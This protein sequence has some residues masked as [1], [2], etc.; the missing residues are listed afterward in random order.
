MNLTNLLFGKL[1]C[2]FADSDAGG[3]ASNDQPI[4][5]KS[6][7][8]D[9]GGGD[10]TPTDFVEFEGV[11]IPADAFDKVARERHKDAFESHE[12]REKWQ[13]ENTQQAQEHAE[14]RRKAAEFDRLQYD[15][16]LQQP[17]QQ[18][19]GIDQ[20]YVRDAQQMFGSNVDPRFLEMT[21]R[22]V[23][24][25]TKEG[26]EEAVGPLRNQQGESFETVFMKDHPLVKKGS[27]KYFQVSEK[28]KAGYD[29]EDAYQLIYAPEISEQNFQDRLKTRDE[30]TKRKLQQARTPG[31]RGV[32][33]KPATHKERA[34]A[35]IDEMYTP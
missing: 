6:N 14:F 21:A 1:W 23:A 9:A 27:E 4:D 3:G 18:P 16:R 30:D 29:A 25:K 8:D 11:K 32:G 19:L 2:S 26:I 10:A 34:A 22:F 20:E 24:K 33:G 17:T 15:P 7:P 13:A 12:N 31:Q 5:D 35:I 28:M